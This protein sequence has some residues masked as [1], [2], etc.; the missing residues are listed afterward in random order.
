M[1]NRHNIPEKR[2][3]VKNPKIAISTK[4]SNNWREMFQKNNQRVFN[5][6]IPYLGIE[7]SNGF[8]KQVNRGKL[9]ELYLQMQ[10]GLHPNFD[11]ISQY[12]FVY[13]GKRCQFKYL[14]QNSSPSISEIKRIEEESN[15]K[16][17]NRILKH[18]QN[19]DI[20]VISLEN[21]ITDIN[22]VNSYKMDRKQFKAILMEQAK[23]VKVGNKMRLRKTIVRRVL[24]I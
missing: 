4:E 6:L 17:V 23:T 24:G 12:D 9:A 16:F 13:D 2:E 1:T 18:Y 14:G 20:F 10:L 21:L 19:C 22:W 15:V 5:Q 3:T 8:K 11:K 7:E